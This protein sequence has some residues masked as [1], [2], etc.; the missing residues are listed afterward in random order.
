LRKLLCVAVL[1]AGVVAATP[2]AAGAAPPILQTVKFD[3]ATKVLSASWSLPP[4]VQTSVLEANANPTLDSQGYFLYGPNDGNYGPNNI[5]EVPDSN[6]NGRAS[7]RSGLRR[8]RPRST[9]PTALVGPTS[10]RDRSSSHAVTETWRYSGSVGRS[11][12]AALRPASAS[13][14]GTTASRSATGVISI[15]ALAHTPRSTE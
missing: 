14:T 7:P 12:R 11:G 9:R 5:F 13:T 15:P 2:S 4:G 3:N 6:R 8:P 1:A 10:G